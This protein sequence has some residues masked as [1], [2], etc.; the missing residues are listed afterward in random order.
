MLPYSSTLV[1]GSLPNGVTY[2]GSMQAL[3]A[4]IVA[5]NGSFNPEFAF[6]DS[7]GAQYRV[8]TNLFFSGA[9]STVQ[10]SS[11]S[12][13]ASARV[14][15]SYTNT[16]SACCL[17]SFQWSLIGGSLP[18]GLS[19][20]P[21]GVISGS[22][23]T[24]GPYTFL[25]RA[26]DPI[27]PPNHAVR[28]FT[29]LATP[30]FVTTSFTLPFGNVGASYSQALI[31][32]GGTG[33]VTWSLLPGYNLPPGLLLNA[34]GVIEGTPTHT[35][36]SQFNVR[37]TDSAGNAVTGFFQL[38][39]YTAGSGPPLNFSLT[40]TFSTGKSIL[41]IPLTATGGVPPYA[42]SWTPGA[43]PIPGLRVQTGPPRPLSIGPT[44]PGVLVGVL[45][46][47]GSVSSSVR[48]TDA[49]GGVV[50]RPI[51]VNVS[52]IDFQFSSLNMPR[53][54]VGSPYTFQFS[55][56]GGG[57]VFT[58]SSTNVPPGFSLSSDGVLTGTPANA[59]TLFLTLTATD[60]NTG[61]FRLF[62]TS[63]IV[64]AFEIT[65]PG[66]L[67]DVTVNNV[68]MV[69]FAAPNC[70][71][72]CNWTLSGNPPPGMSMTGGV[73]L[74]MGN[75]TSTGSYT[76]TVQAT[77][78]NGIA[79]KT[80]SLVVK[81]QT[82]SALTVTTSSPGDITVGSFGAAVLA[83]QGGTGP[84][85][86]SIIS[87]SLPPGISLQAPSPV[88][89]GLGPGFS[90]LLGTG[91]QVGEAS[92]TV[93]VTDVLGATATR[94]LTWNV[95]GLNI[96]YRNF[97]LSG[98]TLVYNQPYSQ[99]LLAVG[100]TSAYT[101]FTDTPLPPGLSL[102]AATGLL[103]GTPAN[104]G[105][106]SSQVRVVDTDGRWMRANVSFNIATGTP[107]ALSFSDGANLGTFNRGS[108]LMRSFNL[109]GGVPPYTLTA[110]T[111]L[112]QGLAILS[113][114]SAPTGPPQLAG[115]PLESGTFSFT[116]RA[117]DSQ[118]NIGV[119]TF[120]LTIAGITITVGALPDAS[121]GVPYAQ[122]L[123]AFNENPPTTWSASPLPPGLSVT[124]GVLQGTPTTAG[125][126][127]ITFSASD[128]FGFVR[129][130]TQSL[131]V[132]GLA[133]AGADVLPVATQ[134][135]S[136]SYTFAASGGGP[137]KV[138]SGSGFGGGMVVSPTGTLSGIPTTAPGL[139]LGTVQVTD[140]TSTFARRF[141]L[142]TRPANGS[143]LNFGLTGTALADVYAGQFVQ[144]NLGGSTGAP[145]Y[146]WSVAP[147]STL[148]PGLSLVS[149]AA[150][151]SS[152]G[153][154]N[155][156]LFGV[157][158]VP[159]SYAFDLI[160]TDTLGQ[161]MRRTFTLNVTTIALASAALTSGTVGQPF[162]QQLV[163][164]G[165]TAPYT[166]SVE[167]QSATQPMLPPG[168]S[169][170]S[171]GLLSGVA[172]EAGSYFF[173]LVLEDSTGARHSRNLSWVAFQIPSGPV[174]PSPQIQTFNAPDVSIGTGMTQ[175]LSVST[176][177]PPVTVTWSVV[178]GTL[179]PGLV[180]AT[181]AG[182]T[183]LTGQP[184]AA[185]TFVYTLRAAVS[186]DPSR[187]ADRTFTL[188]VL[189][190]QV[191]SPPLEFM[192]ALDLPLA[193]LGVPYSTSIRLAGGTPPYNVAMSRFTPLPTGLTLSVTGLL[194]GTPQINGTFPIQFEV[195]DAA[196]AKGLTPTMTLNIVPPGNEAPL[197]ITGVPRVPS[198]A[199]GAPYHFALDFTRGGAP[200]ISWSV[201]PGSS[202]PA[203][204]SLAPGSNGAPDHL[205]GVATV[206]G[207]A[208]FSLIA[209]DAS[210]QTLV[211]PMSVGV[212]PLR[213]APALLSPGA[214]NVPFTATFA[215]S[216][217]T[218][219]YSFELLSTGDLPPGLE[220]GG[221][222][223]S[224]MP[225]QAG[226]F[227]LQLQA[228]DAIGNIATRFYPITIDDAGGHAPAITVSPAPIEL[229][230]VQGTLD[231][232]V[233]PVAIGATSG[234]PAFQAAVVGFGG[235]TVTP[236]T[237]L[238]PA[239][240]GVNLGLSGLPLGV[241]AGVLGVVAPDSASAFTAT[242]IVV[243]VL[244]PPPCSYS[245]QPTSGDAPASGGGGSFAV[246]APA[247]C[248][249]TAVPSDSWVTIT[250]GGTGMGSG[251]VSYSVTPNAGT[252]QRNATVDVAG[253]TYTVM[254]FGSACSFAITPN[255]IAATSAGGSAIVNVVASA[256][257]CGWT[258]AG[259]GVTPSFGTGSGQVSVT[260]PPNPNPFAIDVIA[261]IAG[262]TFTAHQTGINCAVSL[263]T[264][265]GSALAAGGAGTVSVT[266]PPGCSYT[267]TG[268]PSWISITS[269]GS[270]TGD[271]VVNYSVQPN[272]TVM[273]RA[274]TMFIGGEPLAL[275]QAGLSCSITIDASSLSTP[276]ASAGGSRAISVTANDASC[277]WTAGQIGGGG[278][279]STLPGAGRGTGSV[280]VSAIGNADALS[281]SADLQIG[282]QT[283]T[284]TQAGTTCTFALQ[285][286]SATAP[287]HGGAGFVSVTA[288]GGCGWSAGSNASWLNVAAPSGSGSTSVGYSIQS[289]PD[290]VPR[291]G[292]LTVAGHTFT[293]TQAPAAC[294]MT[295]GS[296]GITVADAGG[297][298]TFSAT[299]GAACAPDAVSYSNW[300]VVDTGY[301]GSAA[302]VSYAVAP[303][304]LSTTRQGV[305]Q[306][307]DQAFTITQL[308]S[309][310]AF[311]L[312]AYGAFFNK[313]GGAGVFFGSPSALG[314]MPLTGVDLPSI[315][316][317]GPLG[318][319]ALNIFDQPYTV[320]PF[321]SPL[322]AAIRR[323]RIT[324][325]GQI[326]IVKQASW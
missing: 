315:V 157:V 92:F 299:T 44:V 168:I 183:T 100:G 231:P 59:N 237:G 302:T 253:A 326:F 261:T 181:S 91:T 148:P 202:L 111:P 68:A 291:V 179:P 20:S 272:S 172:Q 243:T 296:G 227:M 64:D 240:V 130:Q 6:S 200:P 104:T 69:N 90:Y 108:A 310:C 175:T 89:T 197:F 280:S 307:G 306:I 79:R 277:L 224:G 184:R 52:P 37:A 164:V 192:H 67:P 114:N 216:G 70:L 182:T 112:P 11:S 150:L 225:Q 107:Q 228:R 247:H 109:F 96:D 273:P 254:Q 133:L 268:V 212:S 14:G 318:G 260:V 129:T 60:V 122:P 142:Y 80:F 43:T 186:D 46:S 9:G 276:I 134:G 118:G 73:P 188:K 320:S 304:P 322:T 124:G 196:G 128:S 239:T 297:A 139:F 288:P 294:P 94:A 284:V 26:Q 193:R 208:S 42:F 49:I 187:F 145:P 274:I 203:G 3:S 255:A 180:L 311:S 173:R 154:P 305:V 77:G 82:P 230:Y 158:T 8:R 171:S 15:Q 23:T 10:I 185:G 151:T 282:G 123:L 12:E 116:L 285:S 38:S 241:H 199:V 213:I 195:T 147:G 215:V 58:W 99:P 251:T 178:G 165:G 7:G 87:G 206:P 248:G 246:S 36:L 95:S 298:A 316:T 32:S 103:S 136:Y 81:P 170:S 140:G 166:F 144:V 125:T 39:I 74:L 244:A 135:V 85:S 105:S 323:A 176:M 18:P 218:G 93:Q 222:V 190:M 262:Q 325:G 132:S 289:N 86:W 313:T 48:V 35:G 51:T 76:F 169:L 75:P 121:V 201:A 234:S 13:L 233:V 50:D 221:N 27:N 83:A 245:V 101:W 194:A 271:G 119:R 324:F 88:P 163:A 131:R 308:G 160:A 115:A 61:A 16:L 153:S 156:A 41:T 71:V 321:V 29:L 57:G 97:P 236:D 45:E 256:P 214:V 31:A 242:P 5:E 177:N 286:D 209:A 174:G 312:D 250:S 55:A 303:N 204:L 293:V 28:Q 290:P 257:A 33:P 279:L 34:A 258:A 281:R 56:S 84:Y 191:V 314:C 205:V 65:T 143:L 2:N 278:W 1:S 62:G 72:P 53:G 217:G 167:P 141:V 161:T 30:M 66:V 270:G 126:Y 117:Q 146:V 4:G 226:N 21:G 78:S 269:G 229:V 295:L 25:V 106:F 19:L 210:G 300:I 162:A 232:G 317:L 189:P 47:P 235:A 63:V 22:P 149:G 219:P 319:P 17:P 275:T 249:W 267:A 259:L 211:V 266:T 264:N 223:L 207:L 301:A 159:G 309:A 238:A 292:T 198:A 24:A 40:S 155:T 287:A 110:L 220:L 252:N 54:L 283:V 113:G 102:D 138:F 265:S 152:F 127:P 120:T 137:S 263:S 98:T